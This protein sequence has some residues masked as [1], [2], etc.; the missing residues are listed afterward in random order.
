MVTEQQ[1][2]EAELDEI[3]AK[4]AKLNAEIN[5]INVETQMYPFVIFTGIIVS[6]GTIV[7]LIN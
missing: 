2:K 1:I 6:I 5:K 4:T 3:R 7:K